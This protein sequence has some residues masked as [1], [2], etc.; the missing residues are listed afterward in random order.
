[1]KYC[2]A[3]RLAYDGQVCPRCG[4]ARSAEA[5]PE[6]PCEVIAVADPMA[7][8]AEDLLRQNNIPV[9][10]E[11]ALGGFFT[12]YLG[13]YGRGPVSLCVPF[14]ELERAREILIPVFPEHFGQEDPVCG[15]PGEQSRAE[16]ADETGR[17]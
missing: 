13:A 3:C 2:T 7:G 10:R 8:M 17:D 16:S 11:G 4:K 15:D 12:A 1:M 9:L 14:A 6:D 5:H